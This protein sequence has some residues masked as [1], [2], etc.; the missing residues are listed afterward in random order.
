MA[1]DCNANLGLTEGPYCHFIPGQ[2]F[3][4]GSP[5]TTPLGTYDTSRSL[6]DNT[7]PGYGSGLDGVADLALYATQAA[8]SKQADQY[9][10]R[11]DAQVTKKDRLSFMIYWQPVKSYSINGPSRTV[12][13]WLNDRINN[14][15]TGLWNRVFSPSLLNEARLNAAGWRW[16]EITSNPNIPFGLAN[17]NFGD[18]HGIFPKNGP[19]SFAP[20]SGSVY[21]QW[22][23]GYQDIV[24][25]VH[26]SHN[27]KAGVTLTRLYY[28]NENPSAA[29]PTFNFGNMWNFLN[30]ATYSESGQFNPSTGALAPNRQDDRNTFWGA[31]VQDDWKVNPEL[32]VNLGIRYDY[33]GPYYD[34]DQNLRTVVLGSGSALVSGLSIRKGGNE[35]AVQKG[36]IGPQVGFAWNPRTLD[37]KFV[38]RGGFGLNYNQ[39]EMAITANGG[40][41]PGNV[42]SYNFCCDTSAGI[43]GNGAGIQYKLSSDAHNIFGFPVNPNAVTAYGSNGLPLTGLINV[44]A[45]DPSV[46]TTQTYHYSLD[47]QYDISHGWVATLG[48][49]GSISHHLL[50]Q[51]DLNVIAAAA[52][53]T[54]NPHVQHVNQYSDKGNSNYHSMIATVKHNFSRSYQMEGQYTWSKSM[55]NG[56]QPYYQ[57]MYPYQLAY[58]YGR[59][60]Y[61]VGNSFRVFGMYQPNFFHNHLLHAVADGWTVTGIYNYHTG[62][63]WTP[64]WNS[65]VHQ[66][67]GGSGLGTVRLAAYNGGG[68]HDLSNASFMSGPN[69]AVGNTKNFSQDSYTYFTLPTVSS[70]GGTY[71]GVEVPLPGAPGVA[72][73]SFDGPHYGALDAS[74]TK[75]FHLPQMPVLGEHSILEFRVDAFNLFNQINLSNVSTSLGSGGGTS[76]VAQVVNYNFGQAQNAL[77]SRVVDIQ[78]RFSF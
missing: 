29:R 62:F 39:N 20:P 9:Y 15:F 28:L 59:S 14:A 32:T 6:T 12:N 10:G 55:D 77:G 64:T 37:R 16:N 13:A 65:T 31:F 11:L 58:S 36:N 23:Y 74:I 19:S 47:T 73:N 75:G 42:L 38:L 52:G 71:T 76:G 43:T 44:V 78:A 25:K 60:D 18:A 41:N 8:S 70:A 27:T 61:D 35:Y 1:M 21:D 51:Q 66:F 34:K 3:D 26:G 50:L 22:T 45:F 63:P 72:R 46:K 30:D 24:T 33:F 40:G 67:F 48:Y 68:G 57:D 2:G 7:K 54:L 4:L 56:S 49:Q 53:Y 17:T 69:S 5:L